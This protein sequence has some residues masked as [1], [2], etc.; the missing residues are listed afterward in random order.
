MIWLTQLSSELLTCVTKGKVNLE[1]W[2]FTA[3][4]SV[5]LFVRWRPH[6]DAEYCLQHPRIVTTTPR[7]IQRRWQ[8]AFTLRLLLLTA[9][10]WIHTTPG[11][12][13]PPSPLLHHVSITAHLLNDVLWMSC[14]V[15][16][17]PFF[18]LP[19]NVYGFLIMTLFSSL[20]R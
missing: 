5:I 16:L 8:G 15:I 14:P 3:Y 10:R 1:L 9:P 17:Q 2:S 4:L 7:L 6:W 20:H 12:R 11:C 19:R 13:M 18:S